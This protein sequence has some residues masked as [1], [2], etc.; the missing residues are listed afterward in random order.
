MCESSGEDAHT[1]RKKLKSFSVRV[2][3]ALH[4]QLNGGITMILKANLNIALRLLS[5]PSIIDVL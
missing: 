3:T 4:R 5:I 1:Q 2:V